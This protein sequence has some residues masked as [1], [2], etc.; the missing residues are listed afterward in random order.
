MKNWQKHLKISYLLM[1]QLI[2]DLLFILMKAAFRWI[3]LEIKAIVNKVRDAMQ[4]KI[5]T[6]EAESM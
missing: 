4:A 3:L 5:G 6:A 1:K 2:N